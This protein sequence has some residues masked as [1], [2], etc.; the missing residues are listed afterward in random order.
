MTGNKPSH[1]PEKNGREPMQ[2]GAGPV[3]M[4]RPA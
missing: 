3:G 2:R 4:G 1:V